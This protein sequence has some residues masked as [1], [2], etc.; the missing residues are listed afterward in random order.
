MEK[1]SRFSIRRGKAVSL[2][3]ITHPFDETERMGHPVEAVE[4]LASHPS[5]PNERA[6]WGARFAKCAMDEVPGAS[7]PMREKPSRFAR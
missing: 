6:Q 5:S 3:S 1:R 2:R 4:F 7:A